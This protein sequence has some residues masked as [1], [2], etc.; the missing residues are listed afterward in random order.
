MSTP[1]Q[2]PYN[3]PATTYHQDSPTFMRTV[4]VTG[5]LNNPLTLTGSYANNAAFMVMNTASIIID[6]QGGARYVAMDFHTA[7]V[8]HQLYPV[9]LSYVSASGTGDMLVFYRN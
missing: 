1:V 5:S 8:N 6:L 9:P 4:R 3:Y 7:G 2:P